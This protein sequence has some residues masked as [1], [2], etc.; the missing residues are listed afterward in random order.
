MEVKVTQ[1]EVPGLFKLRTLTIASGEK[2]LIQGPS[3]LGKTTLLHLIG[4]ILKPSSGEVRVGGQHL[5]D[6]GDGEL[7]RFRR[8]KIGIIYQKLNLIEHLSVRENLELLRKSSGSNGAAGISHETTSQILSSLGL[9]EI[10]DRWAS[11]LS[12]GEQQRVAVGRVLLQKPELILAD[13]PTS[14]LDRPNA[15]KV[16]ELL[17][18]ASQGKTL[19]AVSHDE[20]VEKHFDRVLSLKEILS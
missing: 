13:E 3:G 9:G 19:I 7:S 2:V 5:Y 8:E 18:R 10:A 17:R 6:M 12:L 16:M 1:A 20:R 14:S 11:V 4:G 15:D